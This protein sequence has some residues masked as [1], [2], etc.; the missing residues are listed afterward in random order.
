MFKDAVLCVACFYGL[1]AV[2]GIVFEFDL[3]ALP[4]KQR[5]N[6]LLGLASIVFVLLATLLG[7][8]GRLL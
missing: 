1:L 2:I 3:T 7:A 6:H 4:R 8:L 5:I